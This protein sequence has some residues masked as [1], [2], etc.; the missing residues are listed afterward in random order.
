MTSRFI[1]QCGPFPRKRLLEG[2]IWNRR[3]NGEIYPQWP[4]ISAVS[5]SSA[6]NGKKE[7]CNCVGVFTD[8]SQIKQPKQLAH[9]AHYD[10]L[11]G[12]PN[13]LLVQSR[14]HH[15]VERAQRYNLRVVTLYIDLDRFKNVNDS[16]ASDRDELLIKLT[17]RLKNRLRGR[18][19]GLPGWG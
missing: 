14:L 8:I 13:R 4:T 19:T 5:I 15:A 1:R 2:E 18:C 16:L 7:L 12:L 3:K 17:E 11:T 10:P 6:S 9:L